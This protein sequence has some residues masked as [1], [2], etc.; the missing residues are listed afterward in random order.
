MAYLPLLVLASLALWC[1]ILQ[2]RGGDPHTIWYGDPLI[3]VGGI[4]AMICA[5]TVG[6]LTTYFYVLALRVL[7]RRLMVS[8]G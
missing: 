2:L 1:L 3:G 8:R 5:L 6:F 7:H 4:A